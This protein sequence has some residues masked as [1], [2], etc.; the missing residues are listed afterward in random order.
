[1]E[2][3]KPLVTVI[4]PHHMNENDSYLQWCL[5]SVLA[6]VGVDI[7]VICISDA[8]ECPNVPD[9]VTLVHNHALNNVTKKWHYGV[10]MAD[11]A[12]K[13]MMIISDDVMVSKYM[14]EELAATAS[15]AGVILG[16]ASNCDSTTR[17][18]AQFALSRDDGTVIPLGVKCSLE[19]IAGLEQ[20]VID[21]PVSQ[22]ILIDPGWI[23]F[24]CTMI[25]KRVIELVGDF[26][27]KLDVRYNDVDYC[28]RARKIGIPAMIHLGVFAL[29]F[30][31]RT[32]PKC[33]TQDEYASADRA[34]FDKHSHLIPEEHGDLL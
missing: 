4:V 20:K 27:E 12:S 21:H 25:P 3:Y 9:R 10:K 28:E 34:W 22:R 15:D 29:H 11:P 31:D 16:P 32:L 18:R 13:Y 17:Y 1:M 24:Y 7:E 6:S 33:T 8:P 23:S 2:Q 26:D 5:V 30:G 14:I 19:E